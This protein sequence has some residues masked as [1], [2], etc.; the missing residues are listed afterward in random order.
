[1]TEQGPRG[2]EK[3]PKLEDAAKLAETF[4]FVLDRACKTDDYEVREAAHTVSYYIDFRA[5]Q[6]AEMGH[7]IVD[8]FESFRDSQP[9][10]ETLDALEGMQEQ[11][12]SV[13]RILG[14]AERELPTELSPQP[15]EPW[16]P[17]Q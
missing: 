9:E 12:N 6:D 11:A 5:Q 13:R 8:A 16:V 3:E 2:H 15:A 17:P 1:M 4:Y 7:A 14:L 10:M